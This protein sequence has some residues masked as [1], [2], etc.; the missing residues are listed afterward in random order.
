M[1]HV[2]AISNQKGGVGKT[3]VTFNLGFELVAAGFS[4]CFVD[5]DPQG[6]L[7]KTFINS[8]NGI[9]KDDFETL[10]DGTGL[11]S[12]TAANS[13]MLY[14]EKS[15]VKPIVYNEKIDLIG[16]STKLAEI[17]RSE[18]DVIFT[19]Q[20]KIAELRE[21]YDV[22]LID[23]LPSFGVLQ[24]AAHSAADYILVPTLLSDFSEDG[25]QMQL[26]TANQTKDKLNNDL[27]LLGILMNNVDGRNAQV[28][29]H[30]R[31]RLSNDYNSLLFKTEI[32]S[33]KKIE[34][35][36]KF[37]LPIGAYKR[38]SDQARQFKKFSAEYLERV[39]A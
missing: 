23:C 34:E 12:A 11:L 15:K 32:T 28:E 16:S 3:T 10:D 27:K 18:M 37:G 5:N 13:Y 14:H 9:T 30:S 19:Y 7:T 22:V 26:S 35:S 36:L 38:Y 31:D 29:R 21:K 4:V 39:G 33:S 6:N 2:T 24:T 1:G 25:V 17:S 8:D 20:D